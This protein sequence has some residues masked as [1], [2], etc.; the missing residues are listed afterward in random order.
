MVSDHDSFYA[1]TRDFTVIEFLFASHSSY[2]FGCNGILFGS[3]SLD[4]SKFHIPNPVLGKQIW[5]RIV[6]RYPHNCC[7]FSFITINRTI[8]NVTQ[9]NT[10]CN[11]NLCIIYII[12]IYVSYVSYVIMLLNLCVFTRLFWCHIHQSYACIITSYVRFHIIVFINHMYVS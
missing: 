6:A 8:L 10:P 3:I 11:I 9:T 5:C 12:H 4:S 2:I 1:G 7:L